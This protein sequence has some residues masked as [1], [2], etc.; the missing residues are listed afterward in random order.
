MPFKPFRPPLQR[1]PQPSNPTQGT[2]AAG[3]SPRDDEPLRKRR[4]IIGSDED[5]DDRVVDSEE[6]PLKQKPLVDKSKPTPAQSNRLG[7]RMPLHG[8]GTANESDGNDKEAY[9]NVLW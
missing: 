5:D 7:C 9:Y 8:I 1:K 3:P 6:E 4:R 2:A